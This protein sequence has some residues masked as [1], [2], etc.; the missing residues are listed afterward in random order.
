MKP[1]DLNHI[2]QTLQA[3]GLGRASGKAAANAPAV[4]VHSISTDSR[5]LRP[6]SLF[7]ALRGERFDGHEFLPHA[8]AAGAVAAVVDCLPAI[9]VPLLPIIRVSDTRRAMGSIAR[10]LRRRLRGKVIAVA[11]SNGKTS[12]KHLI[13]AALSSRFSGTMSPK[14]YNNDIGVPLAIF[15]ADEDQDYLVLEMGTNHPG[16]IENLSRMAEPD[17]AVITN[18]SAEHL[19]GLG[20]LDGVRR[21]N[22]S[23]LSGL[24]PDGTLIYFGDDPHLAD[25]VSGFAGTKMTF[26]FEPGSDLTASRLSMHLDGTR[27]ALNGGDDLFTVPMLGRHAALNALAA[28]AVA[29][30]MG[31]SAQEA[32]LSLTGAA[33]PEMRLQI[34]QVGPVTILNDAYNANPASA[35]AAIQT[36]CDVPTPGRRIAVIGE[37]RELGPTGD[38]LHAELG[39]HIGAAAG[40]IDALYCVGPS[41]RIVRQ[42]AVDAGFPQRHTFICADAADA[43]GVIPARIQD[44]DL[45]LLKASRLVRLETVAQAIAAQRAPLNTAKPLAG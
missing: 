18:C 32:L 3:D 2:R 12:T 22:A 7:I 37:M 20:D 16:E 41:A 40:V 6:G 17:I 9:P 44:D 10:M 24:K 26:G 33:G 21:E 30:R 38:A 19:E 45:V 31:L 4:M 23:I 43:A 5:H 25:A 15:P 42:A 35:L 1:V 11:G 29:M 28:A 13:H 39:R 36:L 27:F 14:S 34:E 8:A